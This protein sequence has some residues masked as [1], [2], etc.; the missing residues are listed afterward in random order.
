MNKNNFSFELVSAGLFI[1]LSAIYPLE[2]TAWKAYDGGVAPVSTG[3]MD[4][5]FMA[6]SEKSSPGALQIVNCCQKATIYYSAQDADVVRV[7]AEALRDDIKRVTDAV[8]TLSTAKPA[9]DQ[10]ILI[11]TV[12]FSPLIDGLIASGKIDV[13]AIKGK[14]E[15]YTAVVVDNP[16]KNVKIALIIAGSDRRGTA[17]G[18]FALSESMGVSPWYWWADVAVPKKEALYVSGSYTQ[19]SPGVKY[20][21]IFLNDEDWGLQPW[22][23]K[24]FEPELGNIGPKTYAT[25]FELLLRLHANCIWP[26]MHEFPVHTTPFY[27]VPG[28]AAMA[29][30]YAIVISTSH[31]EPMMRN[32]HEYD[33]NVHGPYDYWANRDK[34]YKFWEERVKE[35]AEFENIYTIGMRGRDDSGMKGPQGITM[36]DR[37]DKIQNEIIP[38]Q[39]KMISE[40]VNKDPSK[41]PQIF[42]PYK[43]TLLQYQAGLQLSDDITIVWPDDN[44][45]YIRQLSNEAER[46]RSGG[47]GVYYH[48]SYWGV[49]S[50]Y[51]W[52]NS[53]PPG[54]TCIEMMKTWDFEAHNIWL[55]N[56]G[57][58]K[59]M[60]I[61][62]EFFLRMARNPEAFRK[63]DQ[64]AY[65]SQWAAYTFGTAHAESISEVLNE[66]FRLNI[67]KRPEHM[68]RP[69]K[70]FS[71]VDNGDEAQKRLEDFAE[72]T[73]AAQG[74]YDRL[75][76]EQKPGFYELVLFP[77]RA[78]NFV[79]RRDLLAER[80]RLWADQNRAVANELAME[81]K[82]ANDMLFK[83]IEFYNQKNADGKWNRMF[84]PD[85]SIRGWVRD[86]QNVFLMPNVG[87][88]SPALPASLGVAVEGS[89]GVL[90]HNIPGE[91]PVFNS[92][93]DQSYYID[94]FNQGK[95]AM[96]WTAKA[97]SPWILLSHSHGTADTRILVSIDWGK[98]PYGD[99]VPGNIRIN[100]ADSEYTI[101]LVIYHPDN[102]DMAVMLEA[103]ENNGVVV[104]EAEDYDERKDSIAGVG[105]CRFGNAAVSD[106]AMTIQP[107]RAASLDPEKITSDTPSL[108]YNFFTIS[109]GTVQ[110]LTQ[111]LPTHRITS[112]HPGLRYAISLNGDKPQI[113]D[114]N[115]IEYSH[116]W[117][118][119]TLRAASIGISSH[120]I[121]NPGLQTVRIWMVD[122]GV[123]LDKITV[124]ISAGTYEAEELSVQSSNT[125]AVI[126]SDPPA[127]GG[128]GLHIKAESN[129][130]F[131]TIVIPDVDAGDYSLTVR[132]KKWNS[133]GIIQ[134][135]VAENP[136]GPFVDIGD[137]YDL[138]DAEG[139]Y[140]DLEPQSVRF[141]SG[142]DKY[143]RFTVTG[144]NRLSN[145]YWVLLD[146]F[147]LKYVLPIK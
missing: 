115:A 12:G 89:S 4:I 131:A 6:V 10:A 23:A 145:N 111:C 14:W 102:L 82:A 47:S 34:I 36:K 49:P 20:R 136:E 43:E 123:V 52:F 35:T 84:S 146:Y 99:I 128:R 40:Y 105:W 92:L 67:I 142:G 141:A 85:T 81:A 28:N 127:S 93:A 21:G 114:V 69:P 3:Y 74:I 68:N 139:I 100:G 62:M 91:L 57:D 97:S 2:A 118:I 5:P 132:V 17:Y 54:M 45:G 29:D 120:K 88:Y 110:V 75:A 130:S 76:D 25:I 37:A 9:S 61:G 7:A 104:I 31:H 138:Y 78:T 108:S 53:T 125:S 94:V 103:V 24:T 119:N 107:F 86:T 121:S 90:K 83:E 56:V 137:N 15:A 26:A 27:Q 51:L 32:S 113:I 129:K 143:L 71:L 96:K 122:A 134:M 109:T 70:V 112:D 126:Y 1:L 98:A 135:A 79:N 116:A 39:R 144:K 55:V 11:G 65:F 101:N 80:S 60:E 50:C 59:P 140:V 38:D 117:N 64:K 87:N 77:V 16:V 95:T 66:Y 46:K 19:R 48:L 133:R 147:K 44:H 33:E 58:L 22:A 106:Y 13:S 8:T 18:V 42:I 63:F 124:K 72:M 41:V 73:S 30:K